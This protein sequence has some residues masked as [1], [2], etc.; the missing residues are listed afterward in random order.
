[1]GIFTI[2]TAIISTI[3]TPYQSAVR[4]PPVEHEPKSLPD[5]GDL[6]RRMQP[7]VP[8]SCH[9]AIVT[10]RNQ[11]LSLS[12]CH[13]KKIDFTQV[14][15]AVSTVAANHDFRDCTEAVPPR[16]SRWKDLY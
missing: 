6:L 15:V 16:P 8:T 1:M 9:S 3:T 5:S 4:Q 13:R 12:Q 10:H 2:R 14:S 11:L 7:R